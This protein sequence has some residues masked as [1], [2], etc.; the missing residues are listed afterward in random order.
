MRVSFRDQRTQWARMRRALVSGRKRY[1]ITFRGP[2]RAKSYQRKKQCILPSQE[3]AARETRFWCTKRRPY[4]DPIAGQRH[5]VG[6]G[7]SSVCLAE[8]PPTD[9]QEH[10]PG[11]QTPTHCNYH[12]NRTPDAA[13]CNGTPSRPLFSRT[14]ITRVASQLTRHCSP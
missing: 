7:R 8:F 12:P 3:E 5:M 14:R 1:N 13:E 11:T 9:L 4:M 10:V 6:M 2:E